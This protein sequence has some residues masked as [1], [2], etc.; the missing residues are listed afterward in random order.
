MPFN[1]FT[2]TYKKLQYLLLIIL[3]LFRSRRTGA[4]AEAWC[5][6]T[7]C[8][9]ANKAKKENCCLHHVNVHS[10]PESQVGRTHFDV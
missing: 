4:N 2:V 8:P 9:T 3:Y 7:P 1:L 10:C 5:H 6:N